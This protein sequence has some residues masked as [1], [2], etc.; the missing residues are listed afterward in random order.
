M[1]RTIL[2]HPRTTLAGLLGFA[3]LGAGVLGTT[4]SGRLWPA[5]A[6]LLGM[7]AAYMV[8]LLLAADAREEGPR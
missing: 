4:A 6:G 7:G 1:L 8:A 3:L 2:R 5:L